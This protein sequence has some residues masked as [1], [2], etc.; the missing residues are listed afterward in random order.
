M[1]ASAHHRPPSGFSVV[2]LPAEFALKD[3]FF[4]VD[5]IGAGLHL[6]DRGMTDFTFELNA[7]DPVWED[8]RGHSTLFGLVIEH[9]IAVK[10]FDGLSGK[11]PHPGA[12]EKCCCDRNADDSLH[13]PLS[14]LCATLLYGISRSFFAPQMPA[15]GRSDG[16][17]S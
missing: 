14:L 12:H 8:D 6:E 2:A 15:R 13:P 9:H 3:D 5:V 1:A 4:H 11:E 16:G 10:A 7:V 17:N